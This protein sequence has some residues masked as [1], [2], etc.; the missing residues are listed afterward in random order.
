MGYPSLDTFIQINFGDDNN[1][2]DQV[3]EMAASCVETIAD[4]EQVYDCADSPKSEIIEF[5]ENL[6][7][8]QFQ[9]IQDFF[10]GMPK[11][12][13]KLK[14]TNPNTGVESEV[15]LEGLASFFA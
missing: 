11:L 7:S 2:I 13:H 4:T 5:F 14:V 15:V 12:S 1:Q 3:F 8:K 9:M 6:N 10:E